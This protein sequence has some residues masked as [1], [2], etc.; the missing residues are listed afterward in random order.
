MD[1]QTF[2]TC[3]NSGKHTGDVAVS[4]NAA[5]TA[6]VTATPSFFINGKLVVGALPFQCTPGT[7]GCEQ[8]DFQTYIETALK[9]SE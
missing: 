6:G 1:A 3:V 8:G 5:R 7:R 9:N 4:S 2:E